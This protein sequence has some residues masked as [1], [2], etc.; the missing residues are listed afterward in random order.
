VGLRDVVVSFDKQTPDLIGAPSIADDKAT[1]DWWTPGQ[2]DS[3]NPEN[4][5]TYIG[6]DGQ[7]FSA[8][9]IPQRQVGNEVWFDKSKPLRVGPVNARWKKLVN[10]SCRLVSRSQNLAPDEKLTHRYEVFLGPKRPALLD[11]YGL[12]EV[13]YYGWFSW[14]AI[15]ML[16]V[17]HFFH[18]YM[19]F[20][21]GLA[22]LMLTV[23]VRL[24]M[25]PLS[26][27]QAINAQKMQEIQP[28]IK[29]IAEQYKNNMEARTKAQQELFKKHKFNPMGGCLPLFLQLPI[30]IGLYRS[31]MVDVELRQAPLLSESIR[32]CSNLAAPDM[33]Y[34]WSWFM[35]GFVTSAQ[36]FFGLGPYFNLLPILTIILFLVQ[37]KMFMP[38]PTDDQAAMQQKIMKF[39]MLF[40]GLL[41]FKVASGLC[42]YFIASSL[43]GVAERKLLPKRAAGQSGGGG[44]ESK[45][46]PAKPKPAPPR[47]TR[48]Q[49]TRRGSGGDG[50]AAAKKKKKKS[51]GRR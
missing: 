40:I 20:N 6:V 43:W 16:Q 36:G 34:D 38:P 4:L 39:M 21:Y 14:V 47:Q 18:D 11:K 26:K 10:T 48:P 23:L 30:F 31:L 42:I 1:Q 49:P 33:L 45:G 3:S 37:Q 9:L 28:E 15:P 5:L 8:V 7:Y 29:R 13:V 27:K 17:L 25:F 50:A 35:P 2:A 51:R 24:C 44:P 22:I 46:P 19:V 41:F 12:K 32:W